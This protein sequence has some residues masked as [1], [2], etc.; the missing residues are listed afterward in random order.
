MIVT[1]YVEPLHHYLNNMTGW[2]AQQKEFALSW[3]ILSVA[4]GLSFLNHDCKLVYANISSR[5]I[6][7][8]A[9]S[10]WKI[11]SFEYLTGVDGSPPYKQYYHHKL[12]NAPEFTDNS[13]QLN[14]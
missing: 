8:S 7:V 11:S 2:S 14:K 5:S 9:S 1:E 13:R 3:G 12:Y 4:K 6:F 10:D